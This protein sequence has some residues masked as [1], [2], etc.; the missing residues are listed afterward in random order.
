MK[1][2]SNLSPSALGS[3]ALR[4]L[5]QQL[6]DADWLEGSHATA[7]EAARRFAEHLERSHAVA[8]DTMPKSMNITARVGGWPELPSLCDSVRAGNARWDWKFGGCKLMTK[9]HSQ[10][11][12]W[13][14]AKLPSPLGVRLGESSMWALQLE[15]D[16]REVPPAAR[17]SAHWYLSYVTIDAIQALEWEL[18]EPGSAAQNPFLPLLQVYTAGFLPFVLDRETATLWAPE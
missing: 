5:L 1:M 14:L 10:A 6:V 15:W 7:P 2:T 9:Q 16:L 8:P 3:P 11:T 13:S 12:G 17:E 18:A 4:D